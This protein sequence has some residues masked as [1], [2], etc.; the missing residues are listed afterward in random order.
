[1]TS[2]SLVLIHQKANDKN[3]N[4]LV[5]NRKAS[6]KVVRSSRFLMNNCQAHLVKSRVS[7]RNEVALKICNETKRT[8]YTAE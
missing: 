8:A 2:P 6:I 3:R 4:S 1:M 5:K 7:D